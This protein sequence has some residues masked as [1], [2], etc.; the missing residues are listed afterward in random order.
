MPL[1]ISAMPRTFS[2]QHLPRAKC[3]KA[4]YRGFDHQWIRIDNA[5]RIKFDQIR[6]E[7]DPF[8]SY[9]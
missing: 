3:P 6:F 1:V 5:A 8:S 4:I 2:D 7:N 9:L